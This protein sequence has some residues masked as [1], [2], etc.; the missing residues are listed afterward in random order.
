ML[1]PHKSATCPA[2][3]PRANETRSAPVPSGRHQSGIPAHLAALFEAG[4]TVADIA[5]ERHGLQH[6]PRRRA[7]AIVDRGGH[8]VLLVRVRCPLAVPRRDA[9]VTRERDNWLETA[10][11]DETG[12][13]WQIG[14]S[15]R[16][17]WSPSPRYMFNGIKRL[18][19]AWG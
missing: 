19:C 10:R 8:P 15:A 5:R 7:K 11:T 18:P 3:V 14:R 12:N 2:G 16:N 13:A 1:D 4:H 6:N 9:V 17:A